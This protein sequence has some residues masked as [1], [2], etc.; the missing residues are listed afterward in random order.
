MKELAR[1]APRR[2][3]YRVYFVG[4]GTAVYLGWRRSSIDVDLHSDREIVF[5]DIQEIK[6][7]LNINI[8]LARPEDFVPPLPESSDRHVFIDK[9][10]AITFYHYDP[11]AQFFSKVARGFQRDLDDARKFIRSGMVDP[12]ELRSLLAR[13]PN[14][15]F[16]KYPS[17][18][19]EGIENAVETFLAETS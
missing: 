8:E 1:R 16:A 11:Y 17:L 18:S 19:R 9:V 2:G 7:R 12:P 14:S 13:I 5:R 6:E 10:G 4:G 3:A 15:A